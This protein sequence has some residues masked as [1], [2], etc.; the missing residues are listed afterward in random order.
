MRLPKIKPPLTVI[1]SLLCTAACTTSAITPG[2]PVS[3][4]VTSN[5]VLRQ[6]V[7][8]QGP[9]SRFNRSRAGCIYLSDSQ[10]RKVEIY[11]GV[12]PY[13]Q[14][15]SLT[16]PSGYGWGVAANK[17]TIFV[18]SNADTIDEYNPCSTKA[19]GSLYGTGAGYPYGM[20]ATNDG[21]VYATE[22]PSNYIDIFAPNGNLM[23][24][25]DE[26]M[27]EVYGFAV[28]KAG[29]IFVSGIT[30]STFAAGID[31]CD[32]QSLNCTATGIV[33]GAPAGIALD[34]KQR[35]YVADQTGLIY[36]YGKPYGPNDLLATFEYSVSKAAGVFANIAL[37]AKDGSIW[38]SDTYSCASGTCAVAQQVMLPLGSGL[39]AATA[40]WSPAQAIG[41][42]VWKPSKY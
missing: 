27:F 4:S 14:T 11:S 35:L 24:T 38:G 5:A 8:A 20:A 29:T 9:V 34:K 18:G 37:D 25:S 12:A 40:P 22:W 28:N 15:G 30:Q 17:K 36:E 3:P 23:Q 39:G 42:A 13:T 10:S 33:Y 6:P 26:N 32:S 31:E 7:P 41:I 2:G 16:S 21:T 1:V 19:N